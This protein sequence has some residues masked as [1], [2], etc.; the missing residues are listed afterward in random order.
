M[1]LHWPAYCSFGVLL[2]L[3]HVYIV[4][5]AFFGPLAR[6]PRPHVLCAVTG[7][8]F[9]RQRTRVGELKTLHKLHKALGPII[10]IGPNE[11]S[12][13]SEEGLQKVYVAGLNKSPWYEKIF[14]LYGQRNLVSTLDHGTHAANRRIIAGW[15]SKSHLQHHPGLRSSS[16]RI[17]GDRLLPMLREYANTAT[18]V[19]VMK[20]FAMVGVD[21]TTGHV[22]G[23]A[24]TDLLG[25]QE[26]GRSYLAQ[27][28]KQGTAFFETY[29]K[30]LCIAAIQS[31]Q[32]GGSKSS[33]VAARRFEGL[34]SA[35]KGASKSDAVLE[36]QT[37]SEMLDHIIATQETNTITWTYICYRLSQHPELQ[38]DLRNEL[39]RLKPHIDIN[40]FD[41]DL[42]KPADID[43]LPLL[44]AIVMETLR[45]HAANPARMRR[46]VPKDGMV[47]HGHRLP[48]GTVVST[49]A[50]CLHRNEHVFPDPLAWR[51]HRW[52]GAEQAPGA[53]R[54]WFWA[55]VSA[56][57]SNSCSPH[58]SNLQGLTML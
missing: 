5:P 38:D 8:W 15:Y 43:E 39:S 17:I 23:N 57:W 22:F 34:S 48:P 42:P 55:F 51:P 19:D 20:L 9:E 44:H 27:C 25:N 2:Y 54:R 26:E 3:V 28:S 21:F 35:N 24:G 31:R 49:N 18:D 13:V 1:D 12:V 50:Y 58:L 52:L 4:W 40:A 33:S 16:K 45:L 14:S 37:A 7:I 6:L 10:L 47:L 56:T 11:V 41:G 46:V 32:S 53:M 30:P 36:T 29:H